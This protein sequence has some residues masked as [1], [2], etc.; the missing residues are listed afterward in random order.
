MG[1]GQYC[2]LGSVSPEA[3]SRMGIPESE[4]GARGRDLSKDVVWL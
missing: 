3:E 2:C 4:G 1:K